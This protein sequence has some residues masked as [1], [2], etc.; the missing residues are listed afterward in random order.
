MLEVK[1]L[2][3]LIREC[4][5]KNIFKP[6]CGDKLNVILNNLL[7]LIKV[8]FVVD[9]NNNLFNAV[10]VCRH[11]LF[12]QAAYRQHSAG[13]GDFSGHGNALP[14]LSSRQRGK[15]RRC[16]RNACGGAVL[17][18]SALRNMNM[19][20]LRFEKVFG[21]IIDFCNRAKIAVRRLCRFFHNL[22]EVSGQ[23]KLSAAVH[24]NGFNLQKL[25]SDSRPC[26]TVDNAHK[27][28]F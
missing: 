22:A 19:N 25:A 9:R 16:N 20:I 7:N 11:G 17:R 18:N 10:F 28:G 5:F 6:L 1:L 26:K 27:V 23:L 14:D 4:G 24:N 21:N 2:C 13:Q 3:R 12:S 15:Q 8:A